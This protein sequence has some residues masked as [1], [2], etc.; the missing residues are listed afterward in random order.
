MIYDEVWKHT[1]RV[2]A[3]HSPTGTGILAYY[4]GMVLDESRTLTRAALRMERDQPVRWRPGRHSGL[5]KWLST[6]KQFMG[7]AIAQFRL[8]AYW[9]I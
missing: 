8:K 1:N 5:P 3:Y 7:E 9:N 2:A 6:N 4:D